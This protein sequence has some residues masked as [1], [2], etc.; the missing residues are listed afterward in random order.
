[1]SY[2]LIAT[3]FL[4]TVL[5]GFWVA[6]TSVLT[7]EAKKLRRVRF[8]PLMILGVSFIIPHGIAWLED[9]TRSQLDGM[10]AFVDKHP[11]VIVR[12][13]EFRYAK[14]LEAI[15][16][17]KTKKDSL[18]KTLAMAPKVIGWSPQRG[19]VQVSLIQ[20]ARAC[21]PNHWLPGSTP[22]YSVPLDRS[23]VKKMM[24]KHLENATHSEDGH[25]CDFDILLKLI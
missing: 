22:F 19:E 5:L 13:L 11:P 6:T 16:S 14:E 12:D 10:K 9:K 3:A 18:M 2:P 25:F 20:S 23:K 15:E 4:A 7:D 21:Y 1:M 24:S 17:S 8:M